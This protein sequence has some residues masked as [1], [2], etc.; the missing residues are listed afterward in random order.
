MKPT[1]VRYELF[2]QEVNT[3]YTKKNHFN[4]SYPREFLPF[5]P[6]PS[7]NEQNPVIIHDCDTSDGFQIELYTSYDTSEQLENV[8]IDDQHCDDH[9]DLSIMFDK[10]LYK[11]VNLDDFYQTSR[12]KSESENKYRKPKS[13]KGFSET[14]K[15]EDLSINSLKYLIFLILTVLVTLRQ[16]PLTIFILFCIL[17]NHK[18]PKEIL[19]P[20][21]CYDH[22]WEKIIIFSFRHPLLRISNRIHKT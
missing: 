7:N 18:P 5:P 14:F 20:N 15:N 9:D 12:S 13:S 17:T 8:F 11:S 19:E 16:H 21:M 6:I 22:N 10:K 1:D 2:T 4:L 3:F